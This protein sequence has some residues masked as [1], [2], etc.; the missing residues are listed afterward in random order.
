MQQQQQQQQHSQMAELGQEQALALL[1]AGKALLDVSAD[2]AQQPSSEAQQRLAQLQQ[3]YLQVSADIRATLQQCRELEQ[4]Q[5]A[6]AEAGATRTGARCCSHQSPCSRRPHSRRPHSLPHPPPPLQH[7][8]AASSASAGQADADDADELQQ[9]QEQADA[10]RHALA[11]RNQLIKQVMDQLRQLVDAFGMWDSHHRHLL[12]HA[13]Q[14]AAAGA[15][16]T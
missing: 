16:A 7:T 2:T 10:L 8:A 3:A 4:Q 1:A 9:L 5:A 12:Q 14:F 11:S 13:V 6:A 15:G